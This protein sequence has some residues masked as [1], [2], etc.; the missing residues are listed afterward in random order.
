MKKHHEKGTQG[1][2]F[3]QI[4]SLEQPNEEKVYADRRTVVLDT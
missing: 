2:T 3:R 4:R 1:E